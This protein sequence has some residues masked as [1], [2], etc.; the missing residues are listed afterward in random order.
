M[1]VRTPLFREK[2]VDFDSRRHFVTLLQRR[3]QSI[4]Y[5]KLP[6]ICRR[7]PTQIVTSIEERRTGRDDWALTRTLG[8]PVTPLVMPVALSQALSWQH[9]W[10]TEKR[11]FAEAHPYSRNVDPFGFAGAPRSLPVVTL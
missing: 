1:G 7:S 4:D 6:R 9:R 3:K 2:R 5:Y 8:G 11:I 10:S